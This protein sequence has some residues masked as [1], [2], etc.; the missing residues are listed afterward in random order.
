M[1][2]KNRSIL[3]QVAA[4]AAIESGVSSTDEFVSSTQKFYDALLALHVE[5][6]ID[7]DYVEFKASKKQDSR[8][9]L[10]TVQ[11]GGK[12]YIDYR[13][14]DSK[15][16]NPRFPDFKAEDGSPVWLSDKDGSLLD[17]GVKFLEEAGLV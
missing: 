6:S 4:K 1:N 7:V 12:T 17:E 5:N 14:S 15:K 13:N 9:A 8:P 10:P 11:V 2:H 3:L 16:K